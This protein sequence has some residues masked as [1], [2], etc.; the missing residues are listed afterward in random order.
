MSVLFK[1]METTWSK[2]LHWLKYSRDKINEIYLRLSLGELKYGIDVK[3]YVTFSD[4]L[5]RRTG[6]Y[7]L[8]EKI[9]KRTSALCDFTEIR[10]HAVWMIKSIK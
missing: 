8:E 7:T 10:T 1:D 9:L 6:N 3:W 2:S 5:I 4:F